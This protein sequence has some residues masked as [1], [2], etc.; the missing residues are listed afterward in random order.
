VDVMMTE[1]VE[2]EVIEVMEDVKNVIDAVLVQD[3]HLASVNIQILVV[4]AVHPLMEMEIA[5][6]VPHQLLMT[7][8]NKHTHTHTSTFFSNSNDRDLI[9][10]EMSHSFLYLFYFYTILFKLDY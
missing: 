5:A 6:V 4:E 10:L 2:V 7:S 8:V 1:I 9:I 3:P